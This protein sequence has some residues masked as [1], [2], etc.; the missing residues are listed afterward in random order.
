MIGKL[1][2]FIMQAQGVLHVRR[3]Q[4]HWP[5]MALCNLGNQRGAGR[6]REFTQLALVARFAGQGKTILF[7]HGFVRISYGHITDTQCL[8]YP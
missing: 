1:A 6:T 2:D 5:W 8:Y 4:H 7:R 3:N